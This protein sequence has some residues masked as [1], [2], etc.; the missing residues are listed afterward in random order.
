M[1][2]RPAELVRHVACDAC[3][4]CTLLVWHAASCMQGARLE[5]WM[6][7]LSGMRPA[8][9]I[10]TY[11]GSNTMTVVFKAGW[12]RWA[13][14]LLN[15]LAVGM[16]ALTGRQSVCNA[17]KQGMRKFKKIREVRM[18]QRCENEAFV[19]VI[20]LLEQVSNHRGC[21]RRRGNK[22]CL[23][24]A[25]C[26]RSLLPHRGQSSN[27]WR[28]K[29]QRGARVANFSSKNPI[30]FPLDLTTFFCSQI[31]IILSL[32]GNFLDT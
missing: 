5:C 7:C 18:E 30:S 26:K 23:S 10:W 17:E 29:L 20:C 1:R 13:E 22:V 19:G 32:L 24:C 3:L 4:A 25:L 27:C 16:T 31:K 21:H 14:A 6:G 11:S 8:V 9:L 28:Q 15:V 12:R 2:L